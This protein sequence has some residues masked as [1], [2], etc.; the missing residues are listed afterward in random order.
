M[1]EGCGAL[2]AEWQAGR[3][4]KL[5]APSSSPRVSSAKGSTE[6]GGRGEEEEEEEGLYLRT[7]TRK[8]VEGMEDEVEWGGLL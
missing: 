5:L 1:C 4:L 8:R 6:G 3:Q 2:P 7:E